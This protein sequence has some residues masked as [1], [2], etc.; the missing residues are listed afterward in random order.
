MPRSNASKASPCTV[1][2]QGGS[3]AARINAEQLARTPGAPQLLLGTLA[4]EPA[5]LRD[6][7]AR[8]HALRA[9]EGLLDANPAAIQVRAA[10]RLAWLCSAGAAT[11]L[12]VR[13][14]SL[15]S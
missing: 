3:N 14:G 1:L 15:S 6:F 10:G 8:Y 13:C 11:G 4:D 2:L 9:L 12:H 5:G 7:Y